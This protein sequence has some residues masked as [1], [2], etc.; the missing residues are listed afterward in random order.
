MAIEKTVCKII[1]WW[2]SWRDSLIYFL[3]ASKREE[4]QL[5]SI[6]W[7]DIS[8]NYYSEKQY[9]CVVS[10][11]QNVRSIKCKKNSKTFW[12][13]KTS[14]QVFTDIKQNFKVRWMFRNVLYTVRWTSQYE[15]LRTQMICSFLKDFDEWQRPSNELWKTSYERFLGNFMKNSKSKL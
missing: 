8:S 13:K 10:I 14:P 2:F 9:T 6:K 3:A 12:Q 7:S 4:L 5:Q 15:I 1:R 11:H